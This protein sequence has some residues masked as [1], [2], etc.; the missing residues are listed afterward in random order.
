MMYYHI[1]KMEMGGG[2]LKMENMKTGPRVNL[3][4]K[5]CKAD[6]NNDVKKAIKKV[7]DDNGGLIEDRNHVMHGLWAIEWEYATN[8]ASAACLYPK[9][10]RKPMP[11]GKLVELSNRAA[12]LCHT[13]ADLLGQLNPQLN[14]GVL[15]APLP[16]LFPTSTPHSHPP[17]PSP[18]PFPPYP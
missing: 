9:G 17:P 4:T 5:T 13:L 3:V 2:I 8:K 18:P 11:A 15:H 16:S 7:C 1:G 6:P 12:T 10:A 14:R